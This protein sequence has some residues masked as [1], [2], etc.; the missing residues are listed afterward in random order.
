MKNNP[1]QTNKGGHIKAP[2]SQ[3]KDSPKATVTKGDD[4]RVGRKRSK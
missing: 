1:Y 4:L 3:S 2:K